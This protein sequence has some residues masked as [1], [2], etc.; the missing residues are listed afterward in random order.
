MTKI[1]PFPKQKPRRAP[2]RT[3]AIAW[4]DAVHDARDER[5]MQEIPPPLECGT[6]NKLYSTAA[7]LCLYAGQ[8]LQIHD[9]PKLSLATMVGLKDTDFAA[10]L[11]DLVSMNLLRLTPHHGPKAGSFELIRRPRLRLGQAPTHAAK[12]RRRGDEPA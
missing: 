3:P 1:A 7:I 9:T 11:R 6:I 10:A 4:L 8:D 2:R 12:E 5:E